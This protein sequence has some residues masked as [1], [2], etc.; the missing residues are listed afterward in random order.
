MIKG[1]SLT[2][3]ISKIKCMIKNQCHYQLS[4]IRIPM[5]VGVSKVSKKNDENWRNVSSGEKNIDP[6]Y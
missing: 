1:N 4:S 3:S 5:F 2:R 6:S